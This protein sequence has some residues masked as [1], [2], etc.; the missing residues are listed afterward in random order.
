MKGDFTRLTYRPE[1]H[2]SGV[3]MQQGRVQMDADWNE[4]LDI[5][6]HLSRTWLTDVI[7][8][9]GVPVDGGGFR[10]GTVPNGVD[11]TISAG[12]MY[13]KGVL[14]ENEATLTYLQQ[15]QADFPNPP[16]IPALLTAAGASIGLVY[17]DVWQ[18]HITALEDTSIRDVALGGP[19]T[20]TRTRTVW[21][22]KVLPLSGLAI[23]NQVALNQ[24]LAARATSQGKIDQ[25]VA[26]NNQAAA[27]AERLVL[28]GI[29]AQIA[30]LA[31]DAGIDCNTTFPAWTTIV[32][33]PNRRLEARTQP[34]A[35]AGTLCELLPQG[36][37]Q[38]LENQL[39]R[40]EIH[41]PG[42]VG[43]ATFKWSRENG[44][45]VAEWTD[46]DNLV[47]KV[48]ST[49]R[50]G[51]LSF[52]PGDW[53]ELLDDTRD[54]RGE[55]GIMVR[56][57]KVDATSITVKPPLNVVV[58]RAAF[59][60]TPRIRRW[61]HP[62]NDS[63]RKVEIPL[64]NQGYLALEGGV[65]IRFSGND[66]RTGDYWLIPA[67][68]AAP[69]TE[70]GD[71]EW[72]R[73][74]NSNP[75]VPLAQPPLGIDHSFARLAL[76]LLSP[77]GRLHVL[78]DCR[79]LFPPLTALRQLFYL[80]GDGQEALP[81]NALPRPFTV[82]VS[83]GGQPV[84]G[85]AVRFRRI[86]GNGT[87]TGGVA[88]LDVLTD[89]NG[90]AQAGFTLDGPSAV[91]V[92]EAQLLSGA[93]A[94]HLPV[95]FVATP[96]IAAQ[97]SYTPAGDCSLLAPAR[98]VQ[99]A[100][101]ILCRQKYGGG[102][103]CV[104]VGPQ[105]DFDRIDAALKT[106]LDRG[107]R[108][109]CICLKPGTHEL[110]EGLNVGAQGVYL[111]IEGHGRTALVKAA[112]PVRFN[113]FE[114]VTLSGFRLDLGE[115]NAMLRLTRAGEVTIED[116]DIR[117]RPEP[118]Q[119]LIAVDA[120]RSVRVAGNQIAALKPP[121]QSP[122]RVFAFI[123]ALAQLYLLSSAEFNARIPALARSILAPGPQ[124]VQQN[125]AVPLRS[126]L[127]AARPELTPAETEAYDN[128]FRSLPQVTESQMVLLFQNI[129]AAAA[130]ATPAIALMVADARPDVFLESNVIDGTVTLY[131]LPKPP[132]LTDE[133]LGRLRPRLAQ[134]TVQ[135]SGTGAS[136][137]VVS[138]RLDRLTIG[139]GIAERLRQIASTTG[140]AA[141]IDGIFTSLFVTNNQFDGGV[142]YT[143]AVS[144]SIAS[145]GFIAAN[146]GTLAAFIAARS[147]V[148]GNWAVPDGD[149]VRLRDESRIKSQAANTI[150]VL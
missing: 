86:A 22:T 9:T 7:G 69:G 138:N 10:I 12:R 32:S 142:N 148:T 124:A 21:Q 140:G 59:P 11:L 26:A 91:H 6:D 119:T 54:L 128:L 126:S 150:P 43:A 52:A 68:T 18:R 107:E 19:D 114:S 115:E 45:V 105:A 104:S 72:P 139:A 120:S 58:N 122:Q 46:Q 74:P 70:I 80:S 141:A 47:L 42:G 53:V 116:C 31:A 136:C 135:F 90:V 77:D 51:V 93:A 131:G 83:R 108:D 81:G 99:E 125:F 28:A 56:V 121:A 25:A 29:D 4:Q 64:A 94:E 73:V 14:C 130:A 30:K 112:R 85:A 71:I 55:P 143:T 13:V 106:L 118:Q 39:Y 79:S 38:R 34:Q 24:L 37:Y 147:T 92:V 75:P 36:G 89:A 78:A 2:Y 109:I 48:P 101:D 3:R 113:G 129:Y 97:V 15:G 49:G 65:E 144:E 40:V 87:L 111:Q 8:K 60:R 67:R 66:F 102:G 35:P 63:E 100:L 44:S 82:G 50:D 123:P 1:K 5:Q 98:T 132:E 62:G 103:C 149:I 134:G 17:L 41:K 76:I 133:E 33:P 20:A 146:T 61:D 110:P 96:S 145:N 88:Q 57:E 117:G 23:A 95:R 16:A 127:A 84:H 137:K 27:D